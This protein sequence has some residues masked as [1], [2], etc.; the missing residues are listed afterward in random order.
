MNWKMKSFSWVI[1][2]P[3]LLINLSCNQTKT[4]DSRVD[5]LPYYEEATFT[6][7]W[8]EEEIPAGFHQIADFELVNQ[9]GEVITADNFEN[10]IYVAD[11]F[12]TICPGICP[13]MT[14]NMAVLQ[15]AFLEDDDVLLISHSVMPDYDSPDILK[16]YAE[17]KG[18]KSGKWHLV[19]GQREMIYD[20][21]R[22][23]YFVEENL[24]LEK[25]AD[26]FLH[27]ENFVLIDKN[28]RIR[29][30]YNGLNNSSIQQLIADIELLKKES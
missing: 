29:G 21:G 23:H 25:S 5:K 17:E 10:K 7:H 20:L 8:Y 1:I 24:G 11:F 22:N 6:P 9:E 26:D 13:K 3:L 2:S 18:V 16:E 30:I 19:T 4:G 28:K 15:E 14:S 12:F 27:T